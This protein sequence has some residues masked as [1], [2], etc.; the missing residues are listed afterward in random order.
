[1]R[2]P[3]FW[4]DEESWLG[5]LLSPAGLLY[6]A[7]TRKRL[8]RGKRWRAPMPVICVGNVTAGGSGKTPV[9]MALAL[10]A[11]A[12]G[13]SVHCLSRG[14]GGNLRGP[15]LVDPARHGA[16]EVGD[17]PLLLARLAPTWVARDRAEGARNA[18]RAGAQLLILD[19]GLQNPALACD[20]SLLVIDGGFGFGNGRLIPAGPLRE[21]VSEAASRCDA[22]IMVGADEWDSF[23][24]LPPTLP[25]LTAHIEPSLNHLSGQKVVAFA[26]LGRPTK[27]RR[28]L[29][30]IGAEIVDWFPFPDHYQFTPDDL[31]HLARAA[32]ARAARLV[33][34]EKDFV[35]LPAFF[36]PQVMPLGIELVAEDAGAFDQL[37]DK[38][39]P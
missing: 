30:E 13:I 7:A 26:G 27:F 4:A 31:D 12:R 3:V 23:S 14:Y 22:G 16:H 20:L 35:R 9:V 33:T 25:L 10:R 17:E 11:L 36:R 32:E 34:T 29:L 2:A 19:D 1:M 24:R 6:A 21:P 37:L 28:T 39:M 5:M 8:A 15:V 38:V 18:A